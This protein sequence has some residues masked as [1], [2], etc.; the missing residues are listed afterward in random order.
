M[1]I[2]LVSHFPHNSS[3]LWVLLN[4]ATSIQKFKTLDLF[5][6]IYVLYIIIVGLNGI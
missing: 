5:F 2:D 1:A 4:Q 6:N 3:S